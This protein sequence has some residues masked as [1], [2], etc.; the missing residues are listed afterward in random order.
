VDLVDGEFNDLKVQATIG[1]F[2]KNKLY[3][4]A[5]KPS[6]LISTGGPKQET[7]ISTGVW[8]SKSNCLSKT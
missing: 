8:S 2:P 4:E 3:Y 5:M 1:K 6:K 7:G